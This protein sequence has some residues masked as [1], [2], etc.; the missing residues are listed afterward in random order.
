MLK[1][2][3][4]SIIKPIEGLDSIFVLFMSFF[5]LKEVLKLT[6][7]I[8]IAIIITPLLYMFYK[9]YKKH[10]IKKNQIF[11]IFIGIFFASSTTIIDKLALK[12]IDPISYFYFLKLVLIV[13]FILVLFIFYKQ[14]INFKI[15]KKS[16]L[17]ISILAFF[18]MIGS[19]AYFFALNDPFANTGVTKTILSTSIIFSTF[20]GGKYFRENN[21]KEQVIISLFV[22]LGINILV[23]F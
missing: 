10:A 19:Y 22:I 2:L 11:L 4:I 14:R 5:I 16:L 12:I 8:G 23:F 1:E 15:V 3:K 18:T 9:Q 7:F 17:P 13:M 20:I 21:L 6:Q